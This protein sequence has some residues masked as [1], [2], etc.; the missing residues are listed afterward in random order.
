[1]PEAIVGYGSLVNTVPQLPVA[2]FTIY[3]D[4]VT[5]ALRVVPHYTRFGLRLHIWDCVGGVAL[6]TLQ[7]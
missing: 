1:M 4:L 6:R 5:V 7:F 2:R 3:V